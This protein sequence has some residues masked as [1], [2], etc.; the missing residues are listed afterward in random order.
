[1]KTTLLCLIAFVM[2][3]LT[4]PVQA[5]FNFTANSDGTLNLSQYT[6][7]GGD[8]II[9]DTYN[10]LRV[11]TIGSDAFYQDYTVTSITMGTNVA[12]MGQNAIFHCTTLG[13][14]TLPGGVTNIGLGPIIDCQS[15]TSISFSASNQFYLTTNQ[16]LFNRAQT[17]LIEYPG[18]IGGS[19]T[20]AAAVTN[21]GEAF[22]G[23][24]L[25]AIAVNPTN[26]YYSSTNG[27]LFNKNHSALLEYPG[28]A[29]GNY[30][31]PTNVVIIGSAAFEYSTGLTGVSIGTNVTSIQLYAFYDCSALTN[32]SVNSTNLYY[33]TTN[34]VL[35]DKKQTDL[36]QYPSGLAGSYVVAS[37]VTNLETGAFG[38]AFG[39]TS[40]VIPDSVK[41]IGS[42]TFYSC[43]NLGSVSI[44]NGVTSIGQ[45]AFY[46]CTN[47]ADVVIPDSVTNIAAFAFYYCPALASVTFGT[48]LAYLGQEAFGG[49]ENLTNACFSG[50][51]PT[52]GGS[53][54]YYDLSLSTIDYVSG[55][56]GWGA[57]YDGFNTAPCPTCNNAAPEL[58]ITRAGT[59]VVITWPSIFTG[60]TLQ[61]AT[62]LVSS[63]WVTV[64]PAPVVIND[65]YT[66]TNAASVKQTF[67][68]L[69][70]P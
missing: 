7:P 49:C 55:E 60:F 36:I 40:V 37:T 34:G 70:G 4:A 42:E 62:N 64:T 15:L 69:Q 38:D 41:A 20:I 18:G 29:A 47:L 32:I 9:P 13:S 21:V 66:V 2:L 11:T 46:F 5:Q 61:S 44:G 57:T 25:T 14:V 56:S 39:L 26:I 58:T 28:A 24:S 53:V 31:V 23:N 52:D 27:V 16:I 65:L 19:Y 30:A 48:G 1:M 50:P 12:A 45:N 3:V 10:G 22:I 59:K 67:Y 35:F 17:S 8:V 63:A 33:S 54:F 6:G 51:E 43:E 68:R